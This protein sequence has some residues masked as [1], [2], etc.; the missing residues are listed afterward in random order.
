M[1]VRPLLLALLMLTA[2]GTASG[3][4]RADAPVPPSTDLPQTLSLDE[5]IRIF[6][7]RGLELLIAEAA[8]KSAEGAV[9]IAG[10]VP[11]P[12]VI[13]SFGYAFTYTP[14]DPSC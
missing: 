1:R 9:K 2:K 11:N 4:A 8:V 5:A 6:R 7:A 14:K 13:G 12:V 10:A 3:A